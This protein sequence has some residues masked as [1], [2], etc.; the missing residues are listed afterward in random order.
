MG[1]YVYEHG[2]YNVELKNEFMA[3]HDISEGAKKNIRLTFLKC[4]ALESANNKDLYLFTPEEVDTLVKSFYAPT[5]ISLRLM[6]SH[7]N[8][9]F[10]WAAQKG[11][12]QSNPFDHLSVQPDWPNRHVSP[13]N[14]FTDQDIM[15]LEDFCANAQDAVIIRLLFEGVGGK[16]L[17]EISNLRIQDVDFK[18]KTLSLHYG[19]RNRKLKVSSRLLALVQDAH[20]E[21]LYYK[22]NNMADHASPNYVPYQELIPSGYVMKNVKNIPSDR[23]TV[24]KEVLYFRVKR[25]GSYFGIPDITARQII[26]SGMIY[27][28]KEIYERDGVLEK[29]QYEEIGTR[30]NNRFW[31]SVRDSVKVEDIQSAYGVA[32]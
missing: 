22:A 14:V 15:E 26:I 16:A 29:K 11:M 31:W 17:E 7:I 3:Q 4:Y 25:I 6:I 24:S 18:N 1:N 28:A 2:M 21:D 10:L 23:P 12:I 20:G 13:R 30:F 27:A 32:Q 19:H 8:L 5:L 9:Y